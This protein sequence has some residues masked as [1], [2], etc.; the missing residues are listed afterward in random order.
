MS[1]RFTPTRRLTLEE[2]QTAPDGA[3]GFSVTWTALGVVWADMAPGASGLIAGGDT[4]LA[5]VTWRITIRAE[6][7]GRAARPRPGQRFRDGER[8]FAIRAVRE[9]DASGACLTSIA[10]EEVAP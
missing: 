1:A 7:E 4:P 5:R 2:R 8:L 9:A 6:P 3:G 10:E